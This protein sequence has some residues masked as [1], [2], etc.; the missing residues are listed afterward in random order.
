VLFDSHAT[1]IEYLRLVENPDDEAEMVLNHAIALNRP[2]SD[3]R[4]LFAQVMPYLSD[5]L[6]LEYQFWASFSSKEYT[7]E[8][9]PRK[10]DGRLDRDDIGMIESIPPED[11]WQN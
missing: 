7:D 3:L 8:S 5:L 2:S 1:T 10:L 6:A 4:F 9:M 11:W